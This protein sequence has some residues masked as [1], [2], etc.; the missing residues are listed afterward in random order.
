M[1]QTTPNMSIYVPAAGE[2]NYDASFLA[3]M[4]NIDQHDHS[5]PPDNGVQIATQAL[6]DGSVTY[7]KLNANVADNTTGIGTSGVNLNQLILL[8]VLPAI[9]N[10]ATAT[11]FIAKN[12]TLATA[13]TLQTANVNRLTISNPAGVADDP[14]FNL[15]DVIQINGISFDAGVNTLQDYVTGGTFVPEIAFGGL[16][17]GVTYSNQK[18]FYTRIGNIV[19]FRF[20]MTLSS[21]GSSTGKVTLTGLPIS[22]GSTITN[23]VQIDSQLVTLDALY[24]QLYGQISISTSSIVVYEEGSGQS[25]FNIDDTYI[26]NTSDFT[27][28]G[29]YLIG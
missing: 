21:K 19:F 14:T 16:S 4:I 3:G 23:N 22:A 20:S 1:G 26:S 6:E 24:T 9:Y 28:N 12:G 18:G 25:R 10:I 15:P 27:I 7:P 29:F 5:G 2:T 13:R 11:G 8:G 17:V